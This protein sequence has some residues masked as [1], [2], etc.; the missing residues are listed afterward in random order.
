MTLS[1]L[2]LAKCRE[3]KR[4]VCASVDEI[5]Y[6][7]GVADGLEIA[8]YI[9]KRHIDPEINE[10]HLNDRINSALEECWDA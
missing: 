8:A 10:N 6:F 7:S 4:I 1:E 9:V 5:T 2:L 3:Y